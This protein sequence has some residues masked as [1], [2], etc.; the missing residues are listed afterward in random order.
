MMS[1]SAKEKK[2][3]QNIKIGRRESHLLTERLKS[4]QVVLVIIRTPLLQQ[5]NELINFLK[6][7]L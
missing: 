4:V 7:F 6:T 5:H 2:S 1:S 3:A